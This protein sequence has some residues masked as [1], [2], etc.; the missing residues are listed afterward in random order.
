MLFDLC[1]EIGTF[2]ER[3]SVRDDLKKIEILSLNV[4]FL[5]VFFFLE[6]LK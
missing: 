2:W 4:F 5:F 3:E 1:V 6:A